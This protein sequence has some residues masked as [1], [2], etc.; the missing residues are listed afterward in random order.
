MTAAGAAGR[1]EAEKRAVADA[2][3]RLDALGLVSG[4]S[5]NVS[6]KLPPDNPRGLL[7]VTPSGKRYSEMDEGDIVVADFDMEPVEG[8]LA[9]SSESLMHVAIYRSRPD[10][11]AVIHTHSEFATVL[12]VAGLEAPPVIDEMV[13]S[14]GGGIR[15]S[16]YAFPG[17]QELADS[18]CAALEGRKA[19]IIKNHGA[20][21]VG[22]D[23]A[24]A[25]DVSTLVERVS[26][27]FVYARLL[28]RVDA[29]PKEVVDAEAE[30]FR[31]R[32]GVETKIGGHT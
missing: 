29:L 7:A 6:V 23:L 22:R 13:V 21:G 32:L 30:L 28:G 3:K 16:E 15:V 17:S 27:V 25:L 2:A 8:D 18:V 10:V 9:P 19:A 31:M 11:G 26:K 14:L 12:A 5:G 24:E 1:W 20:V 4:S